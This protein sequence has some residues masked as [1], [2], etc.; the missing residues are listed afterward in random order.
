[1]SD[2]ENQEE[3]QASTTKTT[4]KYE[5][6]T[7]ESIIK[8]FDSGAPNALDKINIYAVITFIKPPKV[9]ANSSMIIL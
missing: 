5:Y 7:V 8:K 4:S 6:E 3:H 9:S 1:M 2:K